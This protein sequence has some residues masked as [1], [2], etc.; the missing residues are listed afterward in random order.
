MKIGELKYGNKEMERMPIG[1][2]MTISKGYTC[3]GEEKR[4]EYEKISDTEV[5]INREYLFS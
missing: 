1:Y 2:V 3:E 5:K 4:V